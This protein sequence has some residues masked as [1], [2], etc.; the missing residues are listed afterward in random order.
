LEEE[1]VAPSIAKAPCRPGFRSK[2]RRVLRSIVPEIP[3][4]S[5][6]AVEDL[7][8]LAPEKSEEGMSVKLGWTEVIDPAPRKD[9]RSST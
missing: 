4:E 9:S 7:M 6:E 2:G 8:T 3:A 1:P 5:S